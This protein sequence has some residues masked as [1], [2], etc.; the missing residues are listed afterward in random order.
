MKIISAC[1]CG[2]N[3]KYNGGNN[4]N[5]YFLEMLIHGEVIPMCPEQL[6]GLP[7][8]RTACEIHG[9]TG[10]DLLA[11]RAVALTRTGKD[12]TAAFLKGAQEVLNIAVQVDA[13]GAILKSRSP[14]CGVGMIYDGTFTGRMMSGDGVTAAML[15]QHGIKVWNEQEYLREEGVCTNIESS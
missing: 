13:K 15:K 10:A 3:C 12:V 8:P 4:F 1:L 7:T 5:P 6:G 11:G 9:G 2:I 14:S